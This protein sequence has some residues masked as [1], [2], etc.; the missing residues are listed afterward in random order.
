MKL[1][2][3]TLLLSGVI[4]L[5]LILVL[6]VVSQF[7]FM[8]NY[9]EMETRYSS[10]VLNDELSN[11]NNTISAMNQTADDW[12][13]WD[14]AYSFVSGN[15][16]SFVND[17][18][19]QNIF[20]RLNLNLIMFVDNNGKIVYGR[21]YDL[22]GNQYIDPPKNLMNLTI[23][24]PLLRHTD[25]NGTSG[26]VD[27]PEGPMIIVSKP[28]VTSHEEGPVI[29]TLIMGRF[30]TPDE[31]SSL[32]NIPNNTIYVFEYNDTR[33]SS[34]FSKVLPSLS[35]KTPQN[36]QIQG[37]DSIAAYALIDDIYGNPA[38]ILKSEMNR[39]LYHTYINTVF[40]FIGSILLIGLVFISMILYSLDK[41]VLHRLDILI[42]EILDI[43]RK[44]DLKR[45]VTVSGEDE[46][47]DLASSINSSLSALYKSEMDLEKSEKK[48][49]N[50]FE[51]TGTAMI[52]VEEDM[53]ISM[54][55]RTFERF[56]NLDKDKIEGNMNWIEMIVPEDRKRILGYHKISEDDKVQQGSASNNY[57]VKVSIG[58]DIHD[59]FATYDLIPGTKKILISLIDITDRKTAEGLLKESLK[60]KELLLREIHHRVKNSLQI[61]SSLLS[62]QA[63]DMDDPDIIERYR[64][65][66]NRI[67]T[68]ALIHESLYQST[69][70]SHV[71]FNNYVDVLIDDMMHSY[72][73]SSNIT[74]TLK[75][76][77]YNL[78]IETAVPVGLIINEL[79]SNALK[80]AFTGD[81][82]SEIKIL[83]DKKGDVYCLTIEDSGVGLP[84]DIDIENPDTLGFQLVNALV[85]QLEG[86]INV[87]V[88][89]G[90]QFKINFKELEY[91]ERF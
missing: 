72:E 91:S 21:A 89:D 63:S 42:S 5:V 47:S 83:L 57:E 33:M 51:N 61:I 66:E 67:H 62:L 48:Y 41:N 14:D 13:Q 35:N 25:L 70:I 18:L 84:K 76:G 19:P 40:Y 88:D 53:T 60:E 29:G 22:G 32:V 12:S 20:S 90:T 86:K 59:F 82:K 81:E 34:D 24:S 64:E 28:I 54:V 78:N 6:L 26:L 9:S 68:I 30:L 43:G 3:R 4:M 79:V 8:S 65:S 58:E 23:G 52:I 45:R 77:D 7:I 69:D 31:L 17:N 85:N 71:N 10:H 87:E 39:S 44:R 11:L 15:N 38:L 56:L 80:H 49:R 27:F 50:I 73:A 46:L 37:P 74:T 36:V 1:R 2:S 55:N 16:P 75:L